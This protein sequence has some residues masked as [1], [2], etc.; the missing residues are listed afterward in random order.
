MKLSNDEYRDKAYEY[1]QEIKR[2]ARYI[3]ELEADLK[4]KNE[5]LYK[6]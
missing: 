4:N 3:G 1:E 2:N 6:I 5:Q